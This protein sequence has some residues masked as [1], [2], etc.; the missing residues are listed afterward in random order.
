MVLDIHRYSDPAT[1]KVIRCNSSA[2]ARKVLK[3]IK[4]TKIIQC[5]AE[6]STLKPMVKYEYLFS[7]K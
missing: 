5:S 7:N 3:N 4:C 6:I 1:T 2:N